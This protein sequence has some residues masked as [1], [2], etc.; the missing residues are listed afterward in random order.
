MGKVATGGLHPLLG[1][2]VARRPTIKNMVVS[3]AQTLFKETQDT[4]TA[5]IQW[6][7]KIRKRDFDTLMLRL[8]AAS[9]K[10]A[11]IVENP[12]AASLAEDLMSLS[13]LIDER[14]IFFEKLQTTAATFVNVL[15]LSK[16]A[17]IL[18]SMPLPLKSYVLST[19]ALALV[20]T[21]HAKDWSLCLALARASLTKPVDKLDR[22][23]FLDNGQGVPKI[24][25]CI[26]FSARRKYMSYSWG[27]WSSVVALASLCQS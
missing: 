13:S 23:I 19:I 2:G 3:D 5:D 25:E 26:R 18:I 21:F 15:L 4:I 14:R 22:G 16:H 20:S 7:K 9:T 11:G 12:L 24:W 27:K 10:M 6:L 8:S 17:A 1:T